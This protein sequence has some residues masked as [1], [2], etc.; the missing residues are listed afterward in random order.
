MRVQ[1]LLCGTICF[2]QV[3]RTKVEVIITKVPSIERQR[4]DATKIKA[5]VIGTIIT[6]SAIEKEKQILSFL[7]QPYSSHQYSSILEEEE[8]LEDRRKKL[9]KRTMQQDTTNPHASHG[10]STMSSRIA[11]Y[12]LRIGVL[13]YHL[14]QNKEFLSDRIMKHREEKKEEAQRVDSIVREVTLFEPSQGSTTGT[15]VK[16]SPPPPPQAAVAAVAVAT[17]AFKPKK[18]RLRIKTERRREQC[19]RNQERYRN[20]QRSMA[21]AS[22]N[23]TRRSVGIRKKTSNTLLVCQNMSSSHESGIRIFSF[24]SYWYEYTTISS[25]SFSYSFKNKYYKY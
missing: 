1:K 6:T 4:H 18:K 25:F 15:I 3:L 16:I 13:P 23:I 22:R 10:S 2:E 24:L 17:V 8:K 21:I 14:L 7:L 19:R 5:K 20:K 12:S 11:T 9:L